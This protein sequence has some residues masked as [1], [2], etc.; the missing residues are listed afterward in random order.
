MQ[1]RNPRLDSINERGSSSLVR[2]IA[3]IIAA[4]IINSKNSND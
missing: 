2:W 1:H 3:R 4:I